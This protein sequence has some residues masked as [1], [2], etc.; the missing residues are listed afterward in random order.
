MRVSRVVLSRFGLIVPFF[1]QLW[2][3]DAQVTSPSP[4][5]SSFVREVVKEIG[6][7][8]AKGL[9]FEFGS[10]CES[11]LRG[12]VYCSAGPSQAERA[13]AVEVVA[14]LEQGRPADVTRR[15]AAQGVLHPELPSSCRSRSDPTELVLLDSLV[16]DPSRPGIVF[17]VLRTEPGTN[18]RVAGGA[19]IRLEFVRDG[20]GF[21]LQRRTVLEYY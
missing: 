18:C 16:G 2:P 10:S 5:A 12:P 6:A 19:M 3:L 14:Q 9:R 13:F 20:A 1:V 8:R 11:A 7:G 4:L 21:V 15:L 17:R